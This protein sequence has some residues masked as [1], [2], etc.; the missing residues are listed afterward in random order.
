MDTELT[1]RLAT[2]EKLGNKLKEAKMELIKA[3]AEDAGFPRKITSIEID[4]S[5]QYLKTM[6]EEIK[7]VEGK[8]PYGVVAA[9]FPYDAP[10]MMLARL[11]GAAVLGGNRLRFSFSSITPR[12]AEIITELVAS[13]PELESMYPKDNREFGKE[14]ID[15]PAVRVL[16]ISGAGAVGE[17]YENFIGQFDKIFFAGPGGLPAAVVFPDA[18]PDKAARFISTRAFING[19]QYCT[20]IKRALIHH[21]IYDDIKNRIL[22]EVERI[23]VG[24]PLD[25]D[26]DIGPIKA[27]RTRVLI[28]NAVKSCDGANILCGSMDGEWIT[29][30][31]LETNNYPDLELFGPFL[32]LHRCDDENQLVEAALNT[33]YGFMLAYF[34]NPPQEG[35]KRF[36]DHFGMVYDNPE[37]RFTPLRLPFGG[38]GKSGWILTRKNNHVERRDGAFIYSEELVKKQNSRETIQTPA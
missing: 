7:Y 10:T 31:V 20:T 27:L 5:V 33:R 34:G 1:E 11:G 28:Q 15:D 36:H 24:D 21:S 32:I 2:C 18:D 17:Y 29:P 38:K 26:T 19:G 30:F 37:F 25:S 4:L 12:T 3:A 8:A 35:I 23:K 14:C 6:K 9:V 22:T 13:F 16:F